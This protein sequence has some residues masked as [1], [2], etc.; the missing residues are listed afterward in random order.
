M[1]V[2]NKEQLIKHMEEV[3]A[4]VIEQDERSWKELEGL[5][6]NEEI[7]LDKAWHNG[8]MSAITTVK[9]MFNE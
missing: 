9:E 6:E 2:M 5:L 7:E 1:T 4:D 3:I 8:Y